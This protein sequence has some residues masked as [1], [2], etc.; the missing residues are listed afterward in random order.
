M[1]IQPREELL[2]LWRS[3]VKVSL[4]GDKWQWGGRYDRNSIS[5]AEQLLCII[6]PAT[7]LPYFRIDQPDD[8]ADDILE[9]LRPFGDELDIPQR[10]IELL[11][12]HIEYYTENDGPSFTG[13]SYF[14]SSKEGV[15]PTP[16]QMQ[17][18]VVDSFSMAV[19]LMLSTLSLVRGF[20]TTVMN[21]EVERRLR[22][23]ER[24]AN[25]RLTAAM[26]G[27]LRSF[28]INVF[29]PDSTEGRALLGTVNRAGRS[30]RQVAEELRSSLQ[31][32]RA[33]LGDVTFGFRQ[34]RATEL[35]ENRNRLFEI[36]WTWG[37]AEDA[38]EVEIAPS[39]TN[40]RSGIAESAPFLYFTV[41]A[42][43]G[44]ADLFSGRTTV[45]GLLNEEQQ[46]LASALKLRWEL[47]QRY[48]GT[49][50]TF[51]D[52][53]RWP[54]EDLPWRTTDD[55][56]SD[57]FSLLIV[58]LVLQ[59]QE[60]RG[61]S[62][63]ELPRLADILTKLGERGR[64]T[65]RATRDDAAVRY[66]TPGTEIQLG[67]SGTAEE[68]DLLWRLNDFSPLLLKN[69]LR[70]ARLSR[71]PE[72]RQDLVQTA[73]EIWE[74]VFRRRIEHSIHAGLWDDA[75]NVFEGLKK[76]NDRPSWYYTERIVECIVMA[77]SL[78]RDPLPRSGSIHSYA[79]G[80]LSETDNLFDLELL[81]ANVVDRGAL[82][83]QLEEARLNLNHAH[84][85]ASLRPATAI[86]I[87]M[88]IL[89]MLE[90]VGVARQNAAEGTG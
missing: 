40:Q 19:S 4:D 28:V 76:H 63:M 73:D 48:W 53:R 38:P 31:E 57:H 84:E 25:V 67:G 74:H 68:P 80:I 6:Y 56:E 43:D 27:L 70:L 69:V 44:I 81:E 51:G 62:T 14:K 21:P 33:S 1:R 83:A 20:G 46:R 39:V 30:N 75:A 37:I 5:D 12:E 47:T 29:T 26:V 59:D 89:R 58:S 34:Q 45:L 72:L 61:T 42:L 52:A 22:H 32:I 60:V 23:L 88:E 13:G 77:I 15:E 55:R 17:V 86:G 54:L 50:A 8:T 82:R 18:D 24:I 11:I 35:I 85:I 49:I 64:V 79:R 78:I 65:S 90:R 41:N 16:E 36:G 3:V 10:L 2:N 7:V 9:V 71:D 87:A 66:H